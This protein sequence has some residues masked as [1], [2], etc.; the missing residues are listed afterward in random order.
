MKDIFGR[1]VG[2]PGPHPDELYDARDKLIAQQDAGDV[3]AAE[4][5][6]RVRSQIRSY[7]DYWRINALCA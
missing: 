3:S 2:V 6:A 4:P 1:E 7:E 5:L